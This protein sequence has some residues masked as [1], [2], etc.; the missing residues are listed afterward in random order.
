MQLLAADI[1][2]LLAPLAPLFSR[3][4]WRHV[5]VLLAGAIL[6]P[7]RGMVSSVLQ[8]VGLGSLP[9]F[10]RDHR[11]L[12]RALNRA[13]WSSLG[14]RRILL[15]LLVATFAP[16]GPLVVGIDDT[17]ERR[18]GIKITAAGI[19]RDPVRSSHGHFVKVRG[20]RWSCPQL[21]VPIPWAGHVWALPF[22]SGHWPPPNNAAP[23]SSNGAT[24]H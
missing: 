4:V 18:R 13:V 17:S 19:Y 10:Q 14:V 6:A 2:A 23:S 9:Q 3:P 24:S 20:L 8:A 12:N 7:G 16:A 1:V 22:L 15:G 21:L 11:A 5:Q